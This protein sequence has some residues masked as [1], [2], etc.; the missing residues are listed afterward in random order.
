MKRVSEVSKIT[1]ISRR[2]LQYYDDEGLM[3]VRRSTNNYRL[4]DEEAM[5]RLWQILV[6]REMDFKLREIQYVL[7]L[8]EE[9]QKK[10]LGQKIQEI[11]CQMK[12]LHEQ[13]E[14]IKRIRNKGMPSRP[15]TYKNAGKT[16]VEYIAEI[17]RTI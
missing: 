5:E 9:K 17:K 14:F 3:S 10:Y 1:G 2:T 13:R 16:Y 4:Y 7:E 8:T 6:Y 12:N 11:D 15:E